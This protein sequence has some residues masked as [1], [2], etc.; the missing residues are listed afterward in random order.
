[1]SEVGFR[2]IPIAEG[3]EVYGVISIRDFVGVEL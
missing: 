3:G 1:L 2:H